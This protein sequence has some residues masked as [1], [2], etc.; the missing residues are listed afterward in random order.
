MTE[1]DTP[2]STIAELRAENER[3]ANQC[4]HWLNEA[5]RTLKAG[6]DALARAERAEAD[7]AR[8]RSALWSFIQVAEARADQPG[9]ESRWHEVYDTHGD[10]IFEL[11]SVRQAT[12]GKDNG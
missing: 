9:E 3:L 5:R 2:L 8:L 7:N 4:T 12:G 10:V 11:R 6:Q 1:T